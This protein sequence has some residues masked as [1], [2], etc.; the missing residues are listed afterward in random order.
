MLCTFAIGLCACGGS[1]KRSYS[2][3]S[4][5][6]SNYGFSDYIKDNDPDLYNS[7]KDRYDSI[8]P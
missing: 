6:D 4:K 5:N 3:S 1:S 2:S 7:I 8:T